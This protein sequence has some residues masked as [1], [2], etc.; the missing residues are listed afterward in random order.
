M[1][2]GIL[3]KSEISSAHGLRLEFGSVL[4]KHLEVELQLTVLMLSQC[5]VMS[6]QAA[7]HD[8]TDSGIDGLSVRD[9]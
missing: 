7:P 9:C 2:F 6:K 1:F 4:L 5:V 3:T 8:D